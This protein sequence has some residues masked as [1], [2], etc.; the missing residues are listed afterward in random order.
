MDPIFI[1]FLRRLMSIRNGRNVASKHYSPL[2]GYV[3]FKWKDIGHPN[4]PL[5]TWLP[6]HGWRKLTGR[7]MG[8]AELI[9]RDWL[10]PANPLS[11]WST[12]LAL[13]PYTWASA[14][15]TAPPGTT[16]ATLD[17]RCWWNKRWGCSPFHNLPGLGR[18]GSAQ[19][20]CQG[21]EG[22]RVHT[23]T[24]PWDPETQGLSFLVLTFFLGTIPTSPPSSGILYP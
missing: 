19:G 3:K 6:P 24:A 9:I 18:S 20:R 7:G 14:V 4:R 1:R 10:P 16:S 23:H 17:G 13:L 2:T 15:P 21:S 8:K 5:I 11:P 22:T 12:I